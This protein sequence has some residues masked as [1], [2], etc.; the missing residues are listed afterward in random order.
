MPCGTD[1]CSLGETLTWDICIGACEVAVIDAV[2]PALWEISDDLCERDRERGE[3]ESERE[4]GFGRRV[5][6]HPASFA[7]YTGELLLCTGIMYYRRGCRLRDIRNEESK[8][9]MRARRSAQL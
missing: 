3:E 5:E 1:N 4:A 7:P 8:I 9:D 2:L 6:S